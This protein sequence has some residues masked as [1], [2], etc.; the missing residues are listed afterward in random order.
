M[1][2]SSKNKAQNQFL[3][4]WLIKARKATQSSNPK[5]PEIIASKVL[6][7]SKTEIITK[8]KEAKLSSKEVLKLDNLL[9]R[10]L[11]GRPLSAVI[12]FTEFHGVRLRIN[13]NV[14]SPRAESEEL[15]EYAIK[16][17]QKSAT[18]IDIGTGSGA[19]GLAISKARP[20]LK[21]ILT[22]ISPVALN[23]AKRN[24]RLNKLKD[25]K[26]KN[27]NLFKRF[28]QNILDT[29]SERTYYVANLPY[30]DKNWKNINTK[31]LSFE[32]Y[33]ALFS[34]NH[35]LQIIY[36]F[37]NELKNLSLLSVG[38][39]ALIEHD[40]KQF[41]SIETFCTKMGFQTNKISNFV[42]LIEAGLK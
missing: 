35:G 21:L 17:V 9:G 4:S 40:P 20:D 29:F 42:T 2:D 27:S 8:S 14:L 41:S 31:K 37:L 7:L 18:V 38:N 23:L 32:P 30:V 39:F 33:S 13:P 16:N 3:E 36:N 6:K 34:T 11:V 1:N 24:A 15:V 26:F 19:I 10:L 25:I 5:A 28:D 22:D 12:G